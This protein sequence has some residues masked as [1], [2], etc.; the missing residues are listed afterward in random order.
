MEKKV[1]ARIGSAV[2]MIGGM[3]EAVLQSKKKLSKTTKLKVM[4]ATMLPTLV[5]EYELWNLLKQQESRVQ[6]TQMMV[7]RRVSRVD[8][9]KL[10]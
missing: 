8:R 3:T 6:A 1:E 9:V 7:L 2:R 4:N 10:G 5:Y